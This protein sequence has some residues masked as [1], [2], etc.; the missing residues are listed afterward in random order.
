MALKVDQAPDDGQ[1]GLVLA[2]AGLADAVRARAVA[3]ALAVLWARGE[4][5]PGV[6][7][8]DDAAR[9]AFGLVAGAAEAPYLRLGQGHA[10]DGAYRLRAR[11]VTLVPDLDRVHLVNAS[12]D[13]TSAH[14][15]AAALAPHFASAGYALEAEDA[16]WTVR[17]PRALDARAPPPERA[18]TVD[19]REALP[20]GADAREVTALMTELQMLLHGQPVNAAREAR[21]EAP[22]NGLWLWGGGVDAP[23]PSRAPA[24]VESELPLARGLARAAG[25]ASGRVALAG[26]V[27]LDL[28]HDPARLAALDAARIGPALAALRVGR[29]AAVTVH[30]VGMGSRRLTRAGL[31]RFWRRPDDL[32]RAFGDGT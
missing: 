2:L 17:A 15:L 30:A 10:T 26:W 21:G 5:V 8:L 11:L 6:T 12:P 32:A 29:L 27:G 14:A 7:S 25:I 4:T 18:A 1:H 9:A 20:V 19:L 31:W 13:A 3:P 16:E 28:A 24:A 22:L 23:R